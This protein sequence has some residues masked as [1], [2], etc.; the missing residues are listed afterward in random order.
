VKMT[1]KL[2]L[3][4]EHRFLQTPD[5]KVWTITQCPYEF[6]REYLEVF[7]SVRVI[8][9]VFPVSQAEPNFLPVEG[10]GVEFY[11]MPS[12]KGPFGF[13][14]QFV[15]VRE[16]ARHAV[17]EGSA[18]ILR[19][20]GQVANSVEHWLTRR[21]LPYGLEVTADPYDVLSPAANPHPV[22]PIARRYF[23]R[24][25]QRQCQRA[26]AVSYVTQTYLQNRYPPALD[27]RPTDQLSRGSDHD[28]WQCVMAVSDVSLSPQ[29]FVSHPRN[30]LHDPSCLHVVF[31]G[32]LESFYKGPDV[33][34][35]AVGICKAQGVPV[36][37]RFV[38]IGARMRA[39]QKRCSHLGLEAQVEFVGSV[40]AGEPV[41]R[42]LDQA[43]LFVLPSRA[44]GVPRA[45]LEAMARGLPCI[46]S[47]VG[48]IPELLHEEDLVAPDDP[49][50]LA[51]AITGVFSK[52]EQIERMSV[53]NLRTAQTYSA[54]ILSEQRQRFF[55]AVK[56][57]TSSA[58]IPDRQDWGQRLS[59]SVH[60]T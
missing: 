26:V 40:T 32:T 53:R 46:G 23:T 9:R 12:Y 47:T 33:L 3:T 24:R 5:S 16:R 29:S 8:S 34:L 20:H 22:A 49:A 59:S 50:A 18:V 6:Y 39:L 21:G 7:D 38:G 1:M 2:C 45:M 13:L 19:V 27:H 14:A 30:S 42:E 60:T 35:E 25:L 4:L 51:E 17:P 48:G 43:D 52:P 11:A 28:N 10:P 58:Q 37:V 57:L 55:R 56:E 41:R 36:Q 54:A 15:N 44:E 31:V